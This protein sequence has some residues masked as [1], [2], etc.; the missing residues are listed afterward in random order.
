MRR[1]AGQRGRT[2]RRRARLAALPAALPEQDVYVTDPGARVD[3]ERLAAEVRA[4]FGTLPERQR[5]MFDLVDLQ[6]YDPLEAAVMTGINPATVRVHLFRARSTVRAH[7]IARH[8]DALEIV[9]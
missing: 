1:V 8:G 7:L 9:R 4:F 2:A 6:G 3:R 5:E